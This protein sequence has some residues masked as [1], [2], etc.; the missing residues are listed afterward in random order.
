MSRS[1]GSSMR[2]RTIG[3]SP[4]MP[5]AQSAAAPRRVAPQHVAGRPQRRV[6]VEDAARPG[7]GRG[8]PRPGSMPR[9]WSCT[10][11][12]VQ[13]S[14]AVRSKVA[15]SRYLSASAEASSREGATSVEKIDA[16]ALAGREADAAPQAEDRIEHGARGV[17][18]RPA[19]DHRHR[20]ADAA[21][22]AE[23]SRRGRSR[24]ERRRRLALD[25]DDVGRPDGGSSAD[26]GAAGRQER[27]EL[28]HELG[29]D[30]EVGERRVRG[31]GGRRRQHELGV[32]RQLEL[33]RLR[34][35]VRDRDAADLG[36]VLR[37]DHDLER[38]RDGAVA[39]M[40]TPRGPRRTSTRRRPARPRW[41]GSP[42]D[43]TAPL[44]TSR[45]KM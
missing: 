39:P 17:G 6:G 31:V 21:A 36:V 16:D 1:S 22:A 37:R 3:R 26:R 35:E 29:L 15:G 19:V 10:C 32:G 24:T 45:R 11:A 4:E 43:Q 12:C 7:P 9:W 14:V 28:R 30:E 42:A 38:G 20:R 13:A 44:S 23:E 33:A 5:W 2:T 34:A 40:R 18:Q 8:A 25:G 27:P 41:A